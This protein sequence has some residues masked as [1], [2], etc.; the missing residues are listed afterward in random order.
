MLKSF[1]VLLKDLQ[2]DTSLTEQLIASIQAM[3]ASQNLR[4]Y[5]LS[6]LMEL[7]LPNLPTEIMG[8]IDIRDPSF[9]AQL[10]EVPAISQ[11]SKL[12]TNIMSQVAEYDIDTIVSL[13]KGSALSHLT[14]DQIVHCVHHVF[15]SLSSLPSEEQQYVI[16]EM[17]SITS[18]LL[19]DAIVSCCSTMLQQWMPNS[20]LPIFPSLLSFITSSMQPIRTLL[21]SDNYWTQ[22]L[23]SCNDFPR[24][25]RA[26]HQVELVLED[27]LYLSVQS[28]LIC[29]VLCESFDMYMYR[30][31]YY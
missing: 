29:A 12:L 27:P 13:L 26:I 18:P 10:L 28:N 31:Y 14:S 24:I 20:F 30:W 23:L 21:E 11:N 4:A 5:I 25:L 9:L 22:L 1:I 19:A 7:S 15:S 17:K 2:S 16:Q 8:L 3:D 6:Q